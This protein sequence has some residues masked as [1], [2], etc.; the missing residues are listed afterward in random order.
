MAAKNYHFYADETVI[1]FVF[2]ETLTQEKFD[3]IISTLQKQIC[4]AK[5]KLKTRKKE[6]MKKMRKYSFN[7]DLSLSRIP[8]F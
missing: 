3:L 6:Y 2:E 7:A 1:Y 8:N 5:S 4:G